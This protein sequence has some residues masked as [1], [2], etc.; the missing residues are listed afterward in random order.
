MLNVESYNY[1]NLPSQ[2]PMWKME[3]ESKV[4]LSSLF[5]TEISGS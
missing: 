5:L 2:V 1:G 4:E 3:H